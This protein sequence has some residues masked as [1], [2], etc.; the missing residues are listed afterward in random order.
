[1]GPATR[2]LHHSKPVTLF[3]GGVLPR[4]RLAWESWGRLNADKSNAILIFTGLSPSAH[5]ASSEKDRS[6]GWWEN[7]I[8][9]GKYIDTDTYFVLC[10]NSLGSCM[11]STGPASINPATGRPWRLDFPELAIEDIAATGQLV[12]EHL[13]IE[14]FHAVIGPSMG[15]MTALAWIRQFPFSTARLGL[16]STASAATPMAIAI[17]SLQREAIVTDRNFRD[18]QYTEDAWP[19]TGMRLAR[20]LGMISYRSASEWQ[21]R[22]GR[23]P[24]DYFPPTLFGMRFAVESYLENHARKFVGQF[25]PCSYLNLSS[26]M[27]NFDFS[28]G[29]VS[30]QNAFKNSFDGH[31]LVLGVVTDILFPPVQQEQLAQDIRAAGAQ[32]TCHIFPSEQGHDAFL[33]DIDTFGRAMADWLN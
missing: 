28:E 27:D 31:A 21:R 19:E 29:H 17:R 30:P 6:P 1:M 25:D 26:A 18:G 13:G 9:P 32:A 4:L 3:R 22:F 23:Q 33:V 7:M 12:V 15:G 14:K 20:K 5:A 16:I 11:G 24:Q 10:I 2:Y 8:G